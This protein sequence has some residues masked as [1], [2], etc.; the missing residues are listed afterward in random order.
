MTKTFLVS[1]NDLRIELRKDLL[2]SWGTLSALGRTPKKNND[3]IQSSSL[4]KG[5]LRLGVL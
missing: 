1:L 2:P 4:T 3:K 5:N